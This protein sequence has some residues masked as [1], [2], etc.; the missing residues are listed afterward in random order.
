MESFYF[1]IVAF[2][3]LL[4]VFDLFVGVSNDAVN[5]MQS[6]IGAKVAKYRTVLVVASVGVLL[7]AVMSQ[8][9][10]D[11]ARHGIINPALFSL[12]EV[13]V[14]F[15]A[16]MVSD[17]LVL[18]MFNSLGLPTSTTVSLVF[19]LLGGAVALSMIKTIGT[20]SLSMGEFLNTDKALQVIIAIFVS[21]AIAFI[22]GVITQ[23]L[24]RV[25]FTFHYKRRHLKSVAIFGGLSI[26][27]LSYFILLKGIGHSSLMPDNLQQ[28]MDNNT[29]LLLCAIFC[30]GTLLSLILN[31][32]KINVFKMVVIL[33]TFALAMA[34]AGNDLVNFIGVP[35]AGLDAVADYFSNGGSVGAD[36]YK[37]SVLNS[38]ATSSTLYLCIAGVIMIVALATSKKAK[39]VIQ[40]GLDLSRQDEGNEMFGSSLAARSIVRFCHNSGERVVSQVRKHP[41]LLRFAQWV[42]SR[43][44]K[45]ESEDDVAFDV[46]RASVNIV[47]AA[48]LITLGTTLKL[49]LSTTYVTFMVAM[50][51]SLADRA[52]KRESAVFR[53]TGVIS[54]IGGW[55]VTAGVSFVACAI[56]AI[57]MLY[58]GLPVQILF[59]VAV[60]WVLTRKTHKSSDDD[61]KE[62]SDAAYR[63]MIRT[64]NKDVV[65]ELLRKHYANTHTMAA[66]FALAHY[67]CI[68]DGFCANKVGGM[69][70]I[71]SRIRSQHQFLRKLR[72][73][74]LLALRKCPYLVAAEGNTWFHVGSNAAR[75]YLYALLRMWE[76][77]MEHVD[78]NFK[79]LPRHLAEEYEGVKKEVVELLS[80]TQG[81]ISTSNFS[82]YRD[83]LKDADNLK[84]RLSVMRKALINSM[85]E[86]DGAEHLQ[87]HLVYLNL[88]QETQ[89]LLSNMRHQLR[90][91]KKFLQN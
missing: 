74:E 68:V 11:V 1:C 87:V 66:D 8:G 19:E 38:S 2:L 44:Q 33:G 18:H 64:D 43:F 76:P 27:I 52:W 40:T 59:V 16:V 88:L 4:A 50:G 61:N 82:S 26:S 51:S 29:G 3:L 30:L 83:I 35:L 41:T 67:E 78:N 70:K 6:A 34:F 91:S 85:Q 58:G 56:I 24:A 69:R 80:A 10:M 15:M 42:D 22:A 71:G 12:S 45:N 9:M 60:V 7:G 73:Q 46:V 63:L 21:V 39:K 53:V 79:P 89:Q 84:D 5:F 36:D 62:Q 48:T 32:L 20:P 47:L 37:M 14:L 49:P 28:W 25:V 86:S 23:W 57:A 77:I 17:V 55:F 75:Q 65:W 81:C 72:R 54:V 90:G 31:F 13:M